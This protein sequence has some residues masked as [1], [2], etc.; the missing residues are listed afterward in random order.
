MQCCYYG[1]GFFSVFFDYRNLICGNVLVTGLVID[2]RKIGVM[3]VII[4][5]NLGNVYVCGSYVRH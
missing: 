2:M 5:L 4:S 1:H 3:L